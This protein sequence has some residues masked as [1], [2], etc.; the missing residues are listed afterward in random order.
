MP[1]DVFLNLPPHGSIFVSSHEVSFNVW[2]PNVK[3]MNLELVFADESKT[4]L[5]MCPSE[6]NYFSITSDVSG[7][8]RYSFLLNGKKRR[9]DPAS[10][11]QASGVH[12]PSSLVNPESFN[13]HDQSWK[14]ILE[15]EL[16]IYELHVGTF[17]RKGT[18]G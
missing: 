12:G 14:G 7:L 5:E 10:R 1:E 18:F 16:V 11:F 15:N 9:P 6:K 3:K 8:D 2:A 17:S 4:I 13:W